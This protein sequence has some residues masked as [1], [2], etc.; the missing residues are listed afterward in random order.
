MVYSAA[1]QTAIGWFIEILWW[2][3][4]IRALISWFAGLRNSF[5]AGF[6]AFF[7]E[8]FVSPI[9][10]LIAKSPLG[11]GMLDFSFF[12]SLLLIRWVFGPFL[13]WLAAQIPF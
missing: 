13:L 6:L 1:I 9:R 3:M 2:A 5:I 7:T 8:P 11:G 4:I 12:I 10:K